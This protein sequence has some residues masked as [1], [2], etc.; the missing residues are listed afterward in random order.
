MYSVL[1]CA[2]TRKICVAEW[3][4][5]TYWWICFVYL[6]E[7]C[8]LCLDYLVRVWRKYRI[9]FKQN[10]IFIIL[11]YINSIYYY[12]MRDDY[13]N[14]KSPQCKIDNLEFRW[15]WT[16]L[17]HSELSGADL[18]RQ[19]CK[20]NFLSAIEY[21]FSV[22]GYF[23]RSSLVWRCKSFRLLIENSASLMG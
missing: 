13:Q 4:Y 11:L 3:F 15:P 21:R 1:V 17:M 6:T 10:T 19:K 12:S 2:P 9:C 5:C 20:N 16:W 22:F 7:K 8:L 23:E 18:V 14:H